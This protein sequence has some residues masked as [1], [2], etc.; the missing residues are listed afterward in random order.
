[1]YTPLE[2]GLDYFDLMEQ[3]YLPEDYL[4]EDDEYE[5][6]YINDDDYELPF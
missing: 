5:H 3:Y 2:L 4:P 6:N 1:M